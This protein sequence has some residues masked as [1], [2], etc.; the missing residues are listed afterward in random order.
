MEHLADF[1]CDFAVLAEKLFIPGRRN[2]YQPLED[3]AEIER[4]ID[5]DPFGNVR[6]GK[7]FIS[8]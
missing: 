7:V 4:I 8:Q 2:P 5:T 6:G 3:G 1:L